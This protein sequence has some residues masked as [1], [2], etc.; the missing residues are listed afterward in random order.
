METADEIKSCCAS[1]YA[2]DWARLLLGDSFHPGGVRL[3]EHLGRLLGLDERSRVLDV[4]SGPGTSALHLA[5]RFGCRVLGVDLAAGNVEA[6]NETA[7]ACGLE[8]R[9]SFEVGDAERLT[10]G[11]NFDAVLCE[12]AFCTFP[13]KAAA[14]RT[15]A[16]CLRPG[17]R[18]G[19]SDLTRRGPLPAEL[20]GLL[21][22]VA[23][24]ADA[25][26]LDEY[27]RHLESA[28]L[29]IARTE[30]CSS[31]L[32]EMVRDI[33]TRLMGL[34]LALETRRIDLPG[35]D[36]GRAAAMAKSALQA[37]REGTLGYA[38]LTGTRA[39]P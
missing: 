13:D 4:A 11:A 26:P 16:S 3:T 33:E 1:L 29:S 37:I 27:R 38:I 28:G 35:V 14:A 9:A 6:A 25:R 7:R 24:I 32:A 8:S 12:C 21:A 5:R 10:L 22:W 39:S 18:I 30:D 20:D 31:V 23:C 15:M 36:L 19:L 2:S 34:R 17:G